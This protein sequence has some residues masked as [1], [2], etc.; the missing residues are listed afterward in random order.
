M[1]LISSLT[2]TFIWPL[3]K[4]TG[5]KIVIHKKWIEENFSFNKDK[6]LPIIQY[7]MNENKPVY[8]F[9]YMDSKSLSNFCVCFKDK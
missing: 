6:N 8:L 5:I 4:Q 9:E 1:R 2:L 3:K 7:L